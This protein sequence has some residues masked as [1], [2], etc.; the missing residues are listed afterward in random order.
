MSRFP[1]RDTSAPST[2][3]VTLRSTRDGERILVTLDFG[4]FYNTHLSIAPIRIFLHILHFQLELGGISVP[5]G[6]IFNFQ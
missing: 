2:R 4:K 6:T 3:T 1:T 5:S